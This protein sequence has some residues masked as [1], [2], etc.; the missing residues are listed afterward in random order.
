MCGI[1]G[2]NFDDTALL[3]DMGRLLRHRGPDGDG[4]Y[5]DEDIS[6]G[7]RRLKIIDLS[8]KGKQP[9]PNEDHSIWLTYNGEIYNF[10]ELRA[11]LE[12]RGHVFISKTDSEVLIHAYE[13]FG[14]SFVKKLRGM[15]AF[16]IYDSVNGIFVLARDRI[17]IKPLYYLF[18]GEEFIF[19]SEI[20][21]ILLN[22][23]PKLNLGA[24]D[25]FFTYQFPLGPAT[26][27]DGIKKVNP[28]EIIVFNLKSKTLKKER[29]WELGLGY[30]GRGEKFYINK[31]EDLLRESIKLRLVSD[32]P[33]GIYLS[34]GLDSSYVAALAAELN[35]DIKTFTI[36]FNHHTDEIY[37]A[38]KTAEHLGVDHTEITVEPCKKDILPRVTWH[39]DMPV[40]NI[41]A[42]PTYI[43]AKSSKRHLTVALTGDGGDELFAGYDKYKLMVL[44]EKLR[45]VP[46]FIKKIGIKAASLKLSPETS[47]RL[48]NFLVDDE[49]D[50][51][52]SY[53]SS[54]STAE[55]RNLYNK[56]K[57]PLQDPSDN[58][59]DYFNMS[60][61]ILQKLLN[62]D[63]KTLL[64]DDYLMK[65]DKMTMASAIEARVPILDHEF[66]E[67]AMGIPPSLKIK[68]LRTKY[69]FRKAMAK[70]LPREIIHRKKHGFNIPTSDWLE[71]GLEDVAIQIF[72]LGNPLINPDYCK[73]IVS[74]FK[75]NPRY[76]SRQFWSTF[77]FFLWYK[78]YFEMEKPS[79]NLDDYLS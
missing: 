68:G 34:G 33:L 75:S 45:F 48:E 11:D 15:F 55:K 8:D 39:L 63:I 51:Y 2:F 64:P 14:F 41:A 54:F 13:E 23:R 37:Y 3:K 77:S 44:R 9:M 35:P 72:D 28:A 65:V 59:G 17:G 53:S 10:K 78:M 12:K 71:K 20:K 21:A 29:Y 30:S 47:T 7:H 70:K 24:L 25:Q 40:S 18:N 49:K 19:S 4:Y 57:I 42:V 69:I 36:G 16:A 62:L 73:G 22:V 6:L 67:F 76:Y 31:I 66:V 61:P 60:M 74:K 26:L 79:F 5:S 1:F 43:M 58:I 52:L 46:Q 50:A 27:F 38:K 32:V 56:N